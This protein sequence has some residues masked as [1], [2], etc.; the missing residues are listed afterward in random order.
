[1]TCFRS[2]TLAPGAQYPAITLTVSVAANAPL[3]VDNTAT[4]SG[5]GDGTPGISP[6]NP[7]PIGRPPDL[8]LTKVRTTDLVAG[9]S[10][11]Y[12]IVVSNATTAG[13]TTSA[14]AVVVTDTLP[15][16][17]TATAASGP[18]WSCTVGTAVS[19]TRSDVLPP[20]ASFPP[21][22]LTVQVAPDA[23]GT[24][25]NSATVNGGGDQT[26]G[27]NSG[28]DEGTAVTNTCL[29]ITG[30]VDPN[31]GSRSTGTFQLVVSNP[32]SAASSGKVVVA[33]TP[34]LFAPPVA[35]SGTGWDCQI[36][37]QAV[38]CQRTDTLAPGAQFPPIT[39][40]VKLGSSATGNSGSA[41]FYVA[42]ASCT[43]PA[44]IPVE[45]PG[46]GPT[47]PEITLVTNGA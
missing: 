45:V 33:G 34:P 10:V 41:V 8:S 6:S 7:V 22:T 44:S 13:S 26:P 40:T 11:T 1:V 24:I 18:G 2:D 9:Q 23:S 25:I 38:S 30:S 35:A 16:G 19:C 39:V 28:A 21:I 20:G 46:G 14:V 3:R 12:S 47:G 15:P 43:R 29:A 4:V 5:G 17:L 42:N 37:A 32:G 27:N 31:F 36:V